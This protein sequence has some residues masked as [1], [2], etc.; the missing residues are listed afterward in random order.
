MRALILLTACTLLML[1][2]MTSCDGTFTNEQADVSLEW[3]EHPA[4]YQCQPIIFESLEE[5][6]F[7]L[8]SNQ[9]PVYET[10][11]LELEAVCRA[12]DIC[13]QGP[14][15]LTEIDSANVAAA[16]ELGW[17]SSDRL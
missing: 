9:I 2:S 11:T 4:G 7:N 12:C 17:E 16:M 3:V 10:E 8:E 13:P 14:V 5:A 15:Y 6:V 1:Y